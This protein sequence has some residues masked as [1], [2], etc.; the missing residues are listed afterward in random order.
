M[1]ASSGVRRFGAAALD[2]AF[3][4]AGRYDGF[5]ERGLKL[6]GILQLAIC[7]SKKLVA[8][9]LTSAARDNCLIFQ[10]ML[11]QQTVTCISHYLKK[12]RHAKDSSGHLTSHAL[13]IVPDS[14]LRK[15][16]APLT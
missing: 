12:L 15:R 6:C 8:L 13:N 5:W 4:A 10:V 2:L 16:N 1:Q 9:F 14:L 11:S 3:V 7:W